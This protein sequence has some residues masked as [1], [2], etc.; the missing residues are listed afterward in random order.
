MM[1][2]T[3]YIPDSR[4]DDE[5]TSWSNHNHERR[6]TP[7][8]SAHHTYRETVALDQFKIWVC[9]DCGRFSNAY[10][11]HTGGTHL[12]A[13]K[14][15][16]ADDVIVITGQAVVPP[17][18]EWDDLFG[19]GTIHGLLVA[20]EYSA[21]DDIKDF[22]RDAEWPKPSRFYRRWVPDW[23]VW[24]VKQTLRDEFH[25]HMVNRDWIVID[26]PHLRQQT[27]E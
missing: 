18:P 26:L 4:G 25:K 22:K 15:L 9:P 3:R 10:A 12:T 19:D 5:V 6:S 11:P 24:V 13:P 7:E 14:D 20:S 8:C 17:S 27:Q 2:Q 23:G 1:D 16:S 21:K